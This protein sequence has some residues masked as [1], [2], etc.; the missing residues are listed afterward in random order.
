MKELAKEYR[1]PD[2]IEWRL[3]RKLKSRQRKELQKKNEYGTKDD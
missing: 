1:M 3:Y 2:K